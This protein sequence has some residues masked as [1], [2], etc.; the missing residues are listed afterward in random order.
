MVRPPPRSFLL[1]LWHEQY[2][3]LLLARLIIVA[4]PAETRHSATLE[5]LHAFLCSE[6]DGVATTV[7][8]LR[9]VEKE[10]TM[11]LKHQAPAPD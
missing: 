6:A 3:A 4:Q 1:R 11:H 2:D 9:P 5:V 7:R 10:L 8:H